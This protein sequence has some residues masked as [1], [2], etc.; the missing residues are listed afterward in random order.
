M[1][2]VPLLHFLSDNICF[3][4]HGDIEVYTMTVSQEITQGLSVYD[5]ISLGHLCFSQMIQV[6]DGV[7]CLNGP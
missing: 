7:F 6:C 3:P 2:D 1:T 5:T 4:V